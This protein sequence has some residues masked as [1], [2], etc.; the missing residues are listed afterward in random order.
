MVRSNL[1]WKKKKKKL[2]WLEKKNHKKRSRG[3]KLWVHRSIDNPG[4]GG[5]IKTWAR[6]PWDHHPS[7]SSLSR[8]LITASYLLSRLTM[9]K[10]DGCRVLDE[11]RTNFCMIEKSKRG[12][13][14]VSS[15]LKTLLFLFTLITSS[16]Q[17]PP[18]PLP[19]HSSSRRP[20]SIGI[21]RTISVLTCFQTGLGSSV[22]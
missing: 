20:V 12:A 4:E 11:T 2:A 15:T 7:L 8:H 3:S 22:L 17:S 1:G 5:G 21:L 13:L 14:I 19:L 6:G 18:H 10:R 9:A 16:G